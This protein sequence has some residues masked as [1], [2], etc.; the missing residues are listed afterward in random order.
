MM[1]ILLPFLFLSLQP[2]TLP[3][4]NT[5]R[6]CR[7]LIASAYSSSVYSKVFAF[8][9]SSPLP[10]PR[11][12]SASVLQPLSSSLGVSGS[13]LLIQE[14]LT[15]VINLLY[16]FWRA[17]PPS[18]PICYWPALMVTALD[19]S[20]GT[21]RVPGNFIRRVPHSTEAV[22]RVSI[23]RW[24]FQHGR[25]GNKGAKGVSKVV[26]DRVTDMRNI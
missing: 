14:D 3:P 15:G 8:S 2:I 7:L 24:P 26:E 11:N 13:D 18:C 23:L 12:P 4:F 1:V 19:Q 16:P 10:S 25:G 22:H 9:L 20:S 17:L 6:G 21:R 5:P